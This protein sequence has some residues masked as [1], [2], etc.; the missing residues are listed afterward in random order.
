[1]LRILLAV[2]GSEQSEAAVD[3]IGRRP[4]PADSEVRIISAIEPQSYLPETFAGEGVNMSLYAEIE[5][6]AHKRAHGAVA[7]AAD[8]LRSDDRSRELKITTQVFSGSPKQVILDEAEAFRAD[9]IVVGSHGRGM[10]ERFLLG[11]VSQAVAL[12]AHCSVEIVRTPKKKMQ[13]NPASS[14]S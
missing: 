9:L 14:A 1:M 3:E 11:S 8:K 12:H 5:N 4:F 7:R 10:V 6:T 2:D 13:P